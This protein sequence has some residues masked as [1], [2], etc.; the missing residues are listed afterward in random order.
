[1]RLIGWMQRSRLEPMR[2]AARTLKSYLNGIL[3]ALVFKATNTLAESNNAKIKAIKVC[4]K[5]YGC[6]EGFQNAIL[7]H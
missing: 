5:A 4:A 1:M 6:I 7:F 2:E 3:N